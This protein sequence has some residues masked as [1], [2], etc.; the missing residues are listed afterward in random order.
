M[1]GAPAPPTLFS[2]GFTAKVGGDSS[3]PNSS[4]CPTAATI[5][6]G[7]TGI[8]S[9]GVEIEVMEFATLLYNSLV[10]LDAALL[11]A[12]CTPACSV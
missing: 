7:G 3:P 5:E 8:L 9:V 6:T 1:G 4:V 12:V 11:T 10:N 2:P